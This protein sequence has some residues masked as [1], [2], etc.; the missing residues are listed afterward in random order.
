MTD[1]M[2]WSY[3][4]ASMQV[5]EEAHVVEMGGMLLWKI[6]TP[7]DLT[8]I[9]RIMFFALHML[10]S[11]QCPGAAKVI[12][13]LTTLP[14]ISL[15]L[16]VNRTDFITNCQS[17]TDW[18]ITLSSLQGYTDC[19]ITLSSLQSYIDWIIT[20]SSLQVYIY[21]IITLSSWRGYIDYIILQ[22]LHYRLTQTVKLQCLF[23][24][25]A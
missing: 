6:H 24:R 13:K 22:S 23:Y 10:L 21:C 8:A 5:Y 20:L 12:Q 17:Y 14:S 9:V 19:I 7:N 18:I 25:V 16:S 1:N 11:L 4:L 15:R 2:Y 3:H